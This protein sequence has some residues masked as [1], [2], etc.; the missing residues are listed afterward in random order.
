MPFDTQ[1]QA[2]TST[3]QAATA[4]AQQYLGVGVD[5]L[6]NKISNPKVCQA[7]LDYD[8][9]TV[10]FKD[11]DNTTISTVCKT[12]FASFMDSYSA[13]LGI[14][15]SY[16]FFSGSIQSQFATSDFSSTT[17]AY[18]GMHAIH[19][20]TACSARPNGEAQACFTPA[21]QN[22][23]KD[24]ENA[25]DYDQIID[26]FGTHVTMSA[27][28]G[29]MLRYFASS[30][31][32]TNVNTMEF[33]VQAQA[34]YDEVLYS[35][36]GTASFSDKQKEEAKNAVGKSHFD[37]IGGDPLEQAKVTG[38]VKGSFAT[39]AG[40]LQADP[41]FLMPGPDGLTP[42]YELVEGE[43]QQ[44]LKLAFQ[45]RFARDFGVMIL[46][47]TGE[48][49]EHPTATVKVPPNFKMISGGA[50]DN[51]GTGYGNMLTASFPA[52]NS[53]WQANGKS[54][55]VQNATT[56]TA[57][58]LV[59][60][61]PLDLWTVQCFNGQP[62]PIA[63]HPV[64]NMA[65]PANQGWAMTGGGAMLTIEGTGNL[66]TAS[67][68][69]TENNVP[70]GWMCSAKDHNNDS[71]ATLTP[72]VLAIK[73][74]VPGVSITTKVNS[75]VSMKAEHPSEEVVLN[76]GLKMVGGGAQ[77]N[78]QEPGNLLTASAPSG[79]RSWTV[80]SKSH[81]DSSPATITGFVIGAKVEIA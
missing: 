25:A 76:A 1:N 56:V 70:N 38:G 51:Y 29:G 37:V 66:L 31:A 2:T 62:G 58:A 52:S 53:S 6:K 34:K 39:W 64:A 9:L 13:S 16:E 43:A 61:D 8:K 23:L 19:A 20:G 54:Q 67:Y 44:N 4:V 26:D 47:A 65:M 71:L 81:Q 57:Y 22:A 14:S 63:R 75:Q 46:T 60:Y 55:N 30:V 79:K 73:S 48:M 50:V 69:H 18:A 40:S 36:G 77:V 21:F 72:Y 24:A 27:L 32:T 49:A 28:I 5:V 10:Q 80:K 17:T 68:P 12:G 7:V 45:R 59:V 3:T 41:S 11:I 74:N 33:S 35:I 15:G 78:W 42:I